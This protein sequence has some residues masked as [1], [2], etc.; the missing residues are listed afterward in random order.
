MT[1]KNT[2]KW[3]RQKGYSYEIEVDGDY[4]ELEILHL[5]PTVQ[6]CGKGGAIVRHETIITLRRLGWNITYIHQQG[7][8]VTVEFIKSGK[9]EQQ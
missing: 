8:E 3:L 9:H 2:L 1:N 5:T 7:I 4:G 6:G